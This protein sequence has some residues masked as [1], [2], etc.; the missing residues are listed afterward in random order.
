MRYQ[1][2]RIVAVAHIQQCIIHPVQIKRRHIAEKQG[3]YNSWHDED[4]PAL[5]VVYR[6]Q[7]FLAYDKQNPAEIKKNVV[8]YSS[9][10]F[11]TTT[12]NPKKNRP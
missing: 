12:D 8:H 10:F 6:G 4:D 7:E 9:L 3:L 5:R 1:L 2:F 11:V